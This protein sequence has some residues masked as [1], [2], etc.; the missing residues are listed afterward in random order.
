MDDFRKEYERFRKPYRKLKRNEII[1]EGAMQSWENGPLQP[2][3][4]TDGGTVG[5]TP[6]DFSDSRDFYNPE[7]LDKPLKNQGSRIYRY[8]DNHTEELFAMAWEDINTDFHGKLNGRGTLDYILAEN[9]NDPRGEVSDRDREVAATVI[10]WLGSS[11]G[12][13]FLKDVEEKNAKRFR[14]ST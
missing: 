1:K 9:P 8:E 4:N 12:Q 14:F 3:K 7:F 11:V 10:Q 6:A 2:I 13:H 5:H